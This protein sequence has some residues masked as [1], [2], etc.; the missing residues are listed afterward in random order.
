MN[1]TRHPHLT[2]L[3]STY[4]ATRAD[5]DLSTQRAAIQPDAHTRSQHLPPP[6]H[7]SATWTSISEL[8]V[9]LAETALNPVAAVARTDA[10][11]EA[12]EKG[13]QRGDMNL[14]LGIAVGVAAVTA[15]VVIWRRSV[16]V[17]EK[18]S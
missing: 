5:L 18:G 14:W 6:L 15:T 8:F 16:A 12:E 7:V 11:V 10:E 13:L 17:A 9:S 2:N 3:P 4:V 1:Q